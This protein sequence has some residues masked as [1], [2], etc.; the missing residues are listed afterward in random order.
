M[1]QIREPRQIHTKVQNFTKVQKQ[2]NG[3]E[4]AFSTNGAGT[5]GY[6]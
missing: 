4:L 3:V 1:E 6:P 5:I 2:S